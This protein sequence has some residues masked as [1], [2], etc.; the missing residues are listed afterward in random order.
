MSA[1]GTSQLCNPSKG[2]LTRNHRYWEKRGVPGPRPWPFFGTY[3]QQF[4]KPFPETEMEWYNDY[5]KIYGIYDGSKPGIIVGDPDLIKQIMVKDFHVFTNRRPVKTTHTIMSKFLSSLVGEEWKRVRSIITP[6]FTSSKMKKIFQIMKNS[7]DT[8]L[9]K[10][11]RAALQ[12]NGDIDLKE[13]YGCYT[14]NVIAKC[15]F[16]TEP[17]INFVKHATKLFTFPFWRKFLDYTVPMWLLDSLKF[18]VLP[19]DAMDFFRSIT[20]NLIHQRLMT[21]QSH[22]S[23]D[24]DFLDLLMNA[25]RVD[26]V[27]ISQSI[28]DID[29]ASF[30][31]QTDDDQNQNQNALTGL[32]TQDVS[33]TLD[34]NEILAQ[35]VL[36]FSVGFETSSQLL[37]YCTYCLALNPDCQ[38]TLYDEIEKTLGM[39][40]GR[41]D[42]DIVL[43]MVYLDA[44]I[45]ETLRLYN[46]V[47]RM[48]R[49][50]SEDYTLGNTNIV[51]RKGMIVG[52]PVWALHHDPQYYPEPYAFKPERF[53]MENREQI[54]PYTYL[55]FGAGPRSCI[56]T[57]F[58]LLESKVALIKV[59]SKYQFVPSKQ[60]R[61]PLR[62]LPVGRP[63]LRCEDVIVGV[64]SRIQ[65]TR[66][67][68]P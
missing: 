8:I 23:C 46:P 2:Y 59:L 16:A 49:Q 64:E 1:Y 34:Q 7:S 48:E 45:S 4:F 68:K 22:H 20:A 3:L 17:D 30:R 10:L 35:S 50:A 63:L 18:T 42:Y 28:K 60:T 62:F 37:T 61:I 55:P 9:E 67:P 31:Q 52:I 40:H 29:D 38:E 11:E 15:A 14:M 5:G 36:F 65:L 53:L 6:T 44:V 21:V 47:L 24:H 41:I 54:V 13:L 12:K 51:I 66:T 25:R 32:V 33:K 27:E 56:G 43:K 19:S 58:A 26:S 57:R 39:N